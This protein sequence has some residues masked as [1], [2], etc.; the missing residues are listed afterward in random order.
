M[1]DTV[2][3]EKQVVPRTQW[4]KLMFKV[5][6]EHFFFF[7]FGCCECIHHELMFMK[8]LTI[9]DHHFLCL[10]Y[11]VDHSEAKG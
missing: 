4:A 10:Y 5:L 9:W 11:E 2:S 3:Y 1:F 6:D 8:K 7:D